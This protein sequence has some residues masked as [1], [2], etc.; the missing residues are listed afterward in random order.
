LIDRSKQFPAALAARSRTARLGASGVPALLAHPDWERPAPVAIWLHG[1]TASKELDPGR[2]LRWI[3]AGLAACAIDLPGHGERGEG[4][5]RMH[6]PEWTLDVLERAVREIDEVVEALRAPQW[7]G[8]FDTSRMAV[9]GMSAGGMATLRRLCDAHPF[10]CAA[11]EGTTG[12][13]RE[14]YFGTRSEEAP[15]PGAVGRDPMRVAKL[16]PAEHL[17]G[18]QPIPLLVLHS[19]KDRIV[20]FAGM[21][22]F[23]ERLRGHYRDAAADPAMIELMTWPETGAPQE[24]IGFGRFSNDA[25]NSQTAFLARHLDASAASL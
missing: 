24:H 13:L 19:E 14:L 12:D 25:K 15:G 11:V 6:G 10:R 3:R 22:G 16:D 20:P 17:A 5:D 2:Y 7:N 1:R 23:V 18:W 21:R 8:A 9:G 4:A